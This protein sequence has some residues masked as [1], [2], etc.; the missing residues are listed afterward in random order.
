MTEHRRLDSS[1]T[2]ADPLVFK[3][4]G[5]VMLIGVWFLLIGLTMTAG[6]IALTIWT[7]DEAPLWLRVVLVVLAAIPLAFAALGFLLTFGGERVTLD[8]TAGQVRIAYGRWWTFRREQRPLDDFHAVEVHRQSTASS[9]QHRG[10]RPT[11]PVRL[12]SA[13]NEVELANVSNYNKARSIAENAAN[14][15]GLPLHEATERETVVRAAGTLDESLA[16][17]A[18]RLGEDVKWPRLPRS[19]RIEVHGAGDET[20]L[21]L[22]RPDRKLLLEG[23][24]GLGFLLLIYGGAIAGLAYVLRDSLGKLGFDTGVGLWPAVIWSLAIIPVVYILG[25]GLVL[26]IARERIAVSPRI[27]KRIWRLPIGA[28]TRRIPVGE[29]EELLSDTD[30]VIIRT[31]ST[32][33]RLGFALNKKE[34]R[35]LR[36]A[37]RYLLVKGSR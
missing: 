8:P 6:P 26:L 34:R 2:S 3:T 23:V 36:E 25:F 32:R 35:W 19:S 37:I 12:L 9:V 14:F 16:E 27:F 24:F 21:D 17:R 30:A 33:C 22:P 4:G 1:T 7:G 31:D 5:M 28:W 18:R 15:T 10:G 29:I 13:D 20:I 11:F